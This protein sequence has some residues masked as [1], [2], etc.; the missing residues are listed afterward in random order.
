MKPEPADG[1]S[2]R[3]LAP[4]AFLWAAVSLGGSRMLLFVM[5]LVLA[6]ILAPEDF[7][8]F[9]AGMAILGFAE[10]LLDLGL[11][12]SLI[13]EQERGFTRRVQSVLSVNLTVAA[14]LTLLLEAIAPWIAAVMRS[15]DQTMLF[16]VLFLYLLLR[17]FGQLPDAILRRDLGFRSRAVADMTRAVVRF[18]VAMSLAPAGFGAWALVAGLLCG[19]AVGCVLSWWLI[20]HRPRLAFDRSAVAQMFHFGWAVVGL[21]IVDVFADDSDYF[22]V[23]HQLGPSALGYYTV[24]YRLPEL[25]LL[26]S[27]WMFATVAFPLYSRARA[28]GLSMASVMNKALRWITVFSFPAGVTLALAS[29]DA[30]T[31]L[32]SDR[33]SP[34]VTPMVLISLAAALGS[35]GYASG[36][37]FSATG[38]PGR[39]LALTVPSTAVLIIS[40]VVVAHRGIVAVAAVHLV[41]NIFYNPARMLLANRYVGAS[42]SSNLRA[43]TPG[44]CAVAGVVAFGLPARLYLAPGPMALTVVLAASGVGAMA[45]LA[46]GAPSAL[47]DIVRLPRAAASR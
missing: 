12:N 31:V 42:W 13:Y 40:M 26:S 15:P 11:G 38:H 30:I 9:A 44:L 19:E 14:L 33:W 37:I 29:R 39:L 28:E 36:D 22:I 10:L 1:G 17:G 24:G 25:L 7:G 5:T 47:G 34:A 16:R 2:T 4:K 6:R 27:Y 41:W 8:V 43:M 20:G 32:F 23:G 35:V 21:R 45:G 46:L 18:T 3:R